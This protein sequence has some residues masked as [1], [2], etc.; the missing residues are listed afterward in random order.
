MICKVFR[1][2]FQEPSVDCDFMCT[3]ARQTGPKK[4]STQG[5]HKLFA[6]RPEARFE[7]ILVK[8]V[9]FQIAPD[10]RPK[11][12]PKSTVHAIV[13]FFAPRS[14]SFTAFPHFT[15]RPGRGKPILASPQ[16]DRRAT[17]FDVRDRFCD[18]LLP[19]KCVDWLRF[20]QGYRE[21]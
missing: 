15:V 1:Q 5:M 3:S 8:H 7:E 21:T 13:R 14:S 17:F 12:C 6:I 10:F 11:T 18:H 16:D 9:P 20:T 2:N 19:R 4:S